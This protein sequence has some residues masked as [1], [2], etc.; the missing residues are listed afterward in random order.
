MN[1]YMFS[2][3]NNV[4]TGIYIWKEQDEDL[5]NETEIEVK[6]IK[7]GSEHRTISVQKVESPTPEKNPSPLTKEKEAQIKKKDLSKSKFKSTSAL[8]KQIGVSSK[9][10]FE[11]FEKNWIKKDGK[12]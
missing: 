12:S 11:I 5:Y 4:E 7:R 6:G 9:E 2:Q 8:S 10:L 3:Q 1:L